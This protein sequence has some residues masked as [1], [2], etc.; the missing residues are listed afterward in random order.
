MKAIINR[1]ILERVKTTAKAFVYMDPEYRDY[2][3][4]SH[5]FMEYRTQPLIINGERQLVDVSEGNNLDAWRKLMTEKIDKTENVYQ[6]FAMVSKPYL[7]G[8]FKWVNS[9]LSEKDYAEMLAHLWTRVE[10]PNT[11]VDVSTSEFRTLFKKAKKKFLMD[12]DEYKTFEALPQTITVYRGL[13]KDATA[14]ALSWTL[15]KSVAEWFA[16]RFDY[17][18]EVVE[19]SIDK[20]YVFAYFDRRNEKEIVLDYTRVKIK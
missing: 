2:G 20:N 18:G 4:V 5:P 16:H 9:D 3:I 10:F 19:G 13:Q 7:P 8:F 14:K 6:I 11:N 17:N 1:T 12:K 15:D